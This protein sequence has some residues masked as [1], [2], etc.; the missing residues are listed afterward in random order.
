M[1]IIIIWTVIIFVLGIGVGMYGD[2]YL[3]IPYR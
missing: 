3:Y 1:T 2:N